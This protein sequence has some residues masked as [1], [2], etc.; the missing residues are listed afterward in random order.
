MNDKLLLY[1]ELSL[2]AHPSLQ[3]QFYD[4]W[5]LRFANGYTKR[6]NSVNLIYPSILNI[7]DKLAEC[8]K[9]YFEQ[10]LSSIFKIT[11]SH[12]VNI[13]QTLEQ[14]G[15]AIIDPVYVMEM[16]LRNK[17]FPP[18]DCILTDYADDEWL[19]AYFT[20]SCYTDDIKKL[21]AK[22]ILDYVKSAT[23]CGR[24]IKNGVTVAC[25]SAVVERGYM[26]LWNVVVN[27]V[28]RGKGYGKEI[29]ESL[30]SAAQ[31]IGAHTAFILVTQDNTTAVNLYKKLGYKTIYSYWYRVKKG[32]A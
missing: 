2:N 7:N 20:F 10:G 18:T 19:N 17:V 25:G 5:I 4:G 27:E 31:Q 8:E 32:G 30:L 26:S 12:D 28:E 9:R 3:T 16:D 14:R 15:Y 13:D 22:Q 21:T 11:D 24:I 23:I 6:A 29:C 1:E